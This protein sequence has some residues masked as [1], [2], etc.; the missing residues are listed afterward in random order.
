MH[1]WN[2]RS[3]QMLLNPDYLNNSDGL[4]R[5]AK[6][7]FYVERN[8]H[9]PFLEPIH[10]YL[11]VNSHYDL[12][13]SS[14]P[15]RCAE[16]GSPGFG[17]E[18]E[19][20]RRLRKK[21]LY[22]GLP[23]EF[24][25]DITVIADACFY[26]VRKCGK[27]IDVG[28]GLISKG[29]FY[30][31]A[32]IVRRENLADVICVP[33]QWHKSILEKNVF[34]PI[35]VSG[36]LKTDNIYHFG[37]LKR[38]EFLNKYSVEGDKRIIL[39]APT[40]NEEL[41]SIPCV[42]DRIAELADD[43][44]VILIKL[45]GMTA[46]HY[47]EMYRSLE[48][49]ISN[50]KVVNDDDFTGAM[51]C[52]DVMVSDVSSAYVEFM[53]LDKPIVLF[54]NPLLKK[55][56]GYDSADIEYQVRDALIEVNTLEELKL[57]VKLSIADPEEHGEKRRSYAKVL[58]ERIDG[59]AAKRVAD[60]I[61]DLL[62][63]KIIKEPDPSILYSVIYQTDRSL[64]KT[65]IKSVVDSIENKN[66][67]INFEVIMVGPY[68]DQNN[69]YAHKV[70]G[71]V[72]ADNITFGS[73][74][75]AVNESGGQFVILLN[76]ERVLPD[77]WIN[78]MHNYFIYYP[79]AGAVKSLSSNENYHSI[80]NK[81][82]DDTRPNELSDIASYFFYYLMGNDLKCDYF[83]NDCLMLK[84]EIFNLDAFID[85]NSDLSSALLNLKDLI[86]INGYTS[87]YALEI[88]NYQN[89]ATLENNQIKNSDVFENS[90]PESNAFNTDEMVV[91]M[92]E[93][94]KVH[95]ENKDF[96][97]AISELNRAK[98]N[99]E[100]TTQT[101]INSENKNDLNQ[102]L[103]TAKGFKNDKDFLKAIEVLENLKSLIE[104]NNPAENNNNHEIIDLLEQSKIHK[105]NKKYLQSIELLEQAKLKIA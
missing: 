47:I 36:F 61:D 55:Y 86:N 83:D 75:E 70:G 74:L 23:E 88:F 95:K 79:D 13:F 69:D 81:F 51:V 96:D 91:E 8:L 46:P 103:L 64:S 14:P 102:R 42:K 93:K 59:N 39:Y 35:R 101:D 3:S 11:A 85:L 18:T 73:I 30:K 99:I 53:L 12:A 60:T 80:L 94:A 34:V 9:L 78:W 65:E 48:K 7:L 104:K 90:L 97:S 1:N 5:K 62:T 63:G 41:S 22:F 76:Q 2:N 44:T 32:P 49:N 89:D 17:L 54:N 4:A 57:A 105:K 67:G 82:D 15:Y 87:W 21:S 71:Y 25:P 66:I 16:Q 24:V 84:R 40:F 52:A 58:S 43:N 10:D 72:T 68:Q 38:K 77:N 29:F 19:Q 20:I 92:L 6:V 26:P 100:N 37:E 50:I 31:D 33:G 27:I 28:H 98:E 56:A 45:H